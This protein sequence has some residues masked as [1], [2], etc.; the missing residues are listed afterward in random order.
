MV[1]QKT[2][3]YRDQAETD[4][5][6]EKQVEL[7][8]D[9]GKMKQEEDVSQPSTSGITQ[10]EVEQPDE[11]DNADTEEVTREE[12]YSIAT[13]RERRLIQKPVR[14]QNSA[15]CAIDLTD[16]D[17]IAFALAL[18]DDAVGDEP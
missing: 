16:A 17:P 8:I 6:A 2:E 5:S 3:S 9:V 12:P 4:H 7:E 13:G 18:E 11:P 15:S 14:Y 1:N 10:P